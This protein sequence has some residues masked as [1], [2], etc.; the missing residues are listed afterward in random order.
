MQVVSRASQEGRLGVHPR[1]PDPLE[2]RPA[3]VKRLAWK[4]KQ[5]MAHKQKLLG[6]GCLLVPCCALLVGLSGT[7]ECLARGKEAPA[8]VIVRMT[9]GLRFK[10]ARVVVHAGDTVEWQNKSSL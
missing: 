2:I 3:Q 6:N 7:G 10:P 8:T 1:I 5:R 9:D 4:R